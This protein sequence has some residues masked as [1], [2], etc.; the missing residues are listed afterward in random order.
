MIT[1]QPLLSQQVSLKE[2]KLEG[3]QNYISDDGAEI[4]QITSQGTSTTVE[5]KPLKP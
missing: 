4:I 5:M 3:D 1:K 2:V